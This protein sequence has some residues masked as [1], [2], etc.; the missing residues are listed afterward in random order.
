MFLPSKS[1]KIINKVN[2]GRRK[3][4]PDNVGEMTTDL[5]IYKFGLM[6]Y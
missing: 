6:V 2:K 5:E 1:S 3:F 4:K